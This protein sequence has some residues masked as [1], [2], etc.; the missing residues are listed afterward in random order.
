M[1]M[2]I[3]G[4][5][6]SIRSMDDKFNA[7]AFG[8]RPPK[9]DRIPLGTSADNCSCCIVDFDLPTAIWMRGNINVFSHHKSL[10]SGWTL[11]LDRKQCIA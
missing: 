6:P 10:L 5:N 11:H 9:L 2:G 3:F 4:T 7:F 8:Y 1:A